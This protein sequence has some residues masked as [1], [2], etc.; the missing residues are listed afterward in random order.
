[1][2]LKPQ[3]PGPMTKTSNNGK[4][5]LEPE[6]RGPA[7]ALILTGRKRE[8]ALDVDKDLLKRQNDLTTLLE[9]LGKVFD[10]NTTDKAYEAYNDF[11][12]CKRAED[13]VYQ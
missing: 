2:C 11:E 3:L 8:V 7:V 5:D 10:T 13:N 12:T 1:M 4:T 6:K 9:D